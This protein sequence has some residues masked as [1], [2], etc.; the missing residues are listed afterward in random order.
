MTQLLLT[1]SDLD[2]D[3]LLDI[4]TNTYSPVSPTAELNAGNL[5]VLE[6]QSMLYWYHGKAFKG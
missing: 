5:I 3:D 6:V 1:A 2:T 4:E